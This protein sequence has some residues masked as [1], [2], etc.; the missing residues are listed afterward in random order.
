MLPG[1]IVRLEVPPLDLLLWRGGRMDERSDVMALTIEQLVSKGV[2]REEAEGL[3]LPEGP[4]GHLECRPGER[5][6][7]LVLAFDAHVPLVVREGQVRAL[8]GTERLVNTKVARFA[9]MVERYGAYVARVR[10]AEGE[11]IAR[12]AAREMEEIDPEAFREPTAYWLIITDQMIEGN[13]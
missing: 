1:A 9:A 11:A 4:V 12:E 2:E 3:R 8:D 6:G 13:L 7:E 10:D 5:D